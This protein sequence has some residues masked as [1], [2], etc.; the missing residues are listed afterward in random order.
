MINRHS[1]H[2]GFMSVLIGPSGAILNQK[3][4]RNQADAI[5]H[6]TGEAQSQAE[7]AKAEIYDPGGALVWT[8]S[9]QG[10]RSP[11]RHVSVEDLRVREA[12]RVKREEKHI[13]KLVREYSSGK[14]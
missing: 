13:L 14:V 3:L 10:E 7:V 6:V 9:Y 11:E 2:N 1:R 5:G 4:W 12:R 8:R